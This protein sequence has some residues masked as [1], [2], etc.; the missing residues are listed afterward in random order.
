[1]LCDICKVHEASIHMAGEGD[2]CLECH[3]ARIAKLCHFDHLK[4]F[5][6]EIIVHDASNQPHHFSITNLLMPHY[7]ECQIPNLDNPIGGAN[8]MFL[9]LT[10]VSCVGK[11]TAGKLI[12]QKLG[13]EFH[14]VDYHVELFY[15]K[16]IERIQQECLGRAGYNYRYADAL[17]SLLKNLANIPSVIELPPSGLLY[18]SWNVV[19]KAQ[20]ITVSLHDKPENILQ[21]IIFT[22][23]DSKMIEITLTNR[24]K[25]AYLSQIRKDITY[26]KTSHNRADFH[27]DISGMTEDQAADK[28]I[29]ATQFKARLFHVTADQ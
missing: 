16:S 6:R 29:E 2:F 19:K 7:S 12:A 10:G 17:S 21:R 15:G 23:I 22:D 25:R 5:A 1:M 3:N 9:F 20:G 28:I 26:F 27:I 18:K 24:E 13:I 8:P 14:S 4:H 11:S